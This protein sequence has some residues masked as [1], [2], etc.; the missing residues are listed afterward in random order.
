MSLLSLVVI[1]NIKALCG[2]DDN[3]SKLGIMAVN[4]N[5]T[6]SCHPKIIKRK[7]DNM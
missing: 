1:I 5:N 7:T 4:V 2:G 6:K 3:A